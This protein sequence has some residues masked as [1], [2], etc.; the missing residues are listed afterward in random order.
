M[1]NSDPIIIALDFES[2]VQA[3][4]LIRQLGDSTSF[5][6]VGL[7]LF[8]NAGPDFVRELVGSGKRVFLD[9][10]L[11]D[12]G[13]TVKRATEQ[14]SRLGATFLT[15]QGS[16]QIMRAA[17]HGRA[18]ANLKLLAVTVLTSW[19]DDD[20]VEAGY[21]SG[22]RNQ[23]HLVVRKAME[24]GMDGV[25]ASPRDGIEIRSQ[26]G[27]NLILV[28]PGIR[29]PGAS[30]ADQ[31]RS[32]TPAEALRNGADYLVI[33]RQVTRSADPAEAVLQIREEISAALTAQ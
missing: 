2:P 13:E 30:T 26:A 27:S 6:K 15:V 17:H 22:V 28:T 24:T 23:V 33:G 31:K 8:T 9:L 7:E 12:I 16:P 20:L 25:I 11:F 4:G 14:V 19:N 32:A 3:W 10:K 21:P 29:S 5:Y 1:H 18:D